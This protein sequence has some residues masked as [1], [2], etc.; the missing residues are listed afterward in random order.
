MNGAKER[1]MQAILTCLQQGFAM[2][3]SD[4]E[5]DRC[6]QGRA[7]EGALCQYAREFRD[8]GILNLGDISNSTGAKNV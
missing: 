6:M 7:A 1:M 4:A 8:C 5:I 2:D 3:I